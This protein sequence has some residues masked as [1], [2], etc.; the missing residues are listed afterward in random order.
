MWVPV[1]L[2]QVGTLNMFGGLPWTAIQVETVRSDTTRDAYYLSSSDWVECSGSNASRGAGVYQLNLKTSDTSVTGPLI[3][4]VKHSGSD[5][6]CGSIKVVANEESDTYTRIGLPTNMSLSTDVAFLSA[7][8]TGVSASLRTETLTSRDLLTAQLTST[9]ASLWT[10]MSAVD[11]N[12]SAAIVNT[13]ASL[14][15]E[16]L[17]NGTTSTQDFTAAI[18]ALSSSL[19]LETLTAKDVLSAEIVATSASLRIEILDTESTLAGVMAIVSSSLAQGITYSTSA[20]AANITTLS[21]TLGQQLT[22]LRQGSEGRWKIHT[23]GPD[24]NR[25]VFYAADGV[26]EMYKVNLLDSSGNPTSNSPFERVPA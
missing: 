2:Y 3:Y 4:F 18:D 17:N 19:R 11:S 15:I 23:T 7:A 22:R 1:R 10:E 20:T 14:R 16:I 25:M 6:H 26:T 21:G 12:L 5:F 8:L 24:A 9:S 13:S